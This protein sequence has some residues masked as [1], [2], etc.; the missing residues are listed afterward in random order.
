MKLCDETL[1]KQKYSI[2]KNWS[3]LCV[4]QEFQHI[5]NELPLLPSRR[6]KNLQDL[7]VSKKIV[8]RKVVQTNEKFKV[9][10]Y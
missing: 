7:L 5:F 9:T 6:N 10:E 3:I 8:I 2:T 1:T 4:N